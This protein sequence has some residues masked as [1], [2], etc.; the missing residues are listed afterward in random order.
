[1]MKYLTVV[2]MVLVVLSGCSGNTTRKTTVCTGNSKMDEKILVSEGDKIITETA[3]DIYTWEQLGLSEKNVNDQET[4]DQMLASYQALY[5][6]SK[7]LDITYETNQDDKTVIFTLVL[8]YSVADLQEL[9]T[10]GIVNEMQSDYVSL[11]ATIKNLKADG[12]TCQ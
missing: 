6:I 8:D 1:M 4:M 11:K 10:F 3:Y 7:G 2:L 9:K 5:G 12:L